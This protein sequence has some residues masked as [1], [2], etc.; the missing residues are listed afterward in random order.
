MPPFLQES[1]KQ[2]S[3]LS[4]HSFPVHPVTQTQ[5]KSFSSSCNDSY[6]NTLLVFLS[7]N[8]LYIDVTVKGTFSPQPHYPSYSLDMLHHWHMDGNRN[9]QCY[10]H[11]PF[12][13]I[14]EH[15]S[16]SMWPTRPSGGEEEQKI[17]VLYLYTLISA[18]VVTIQVA[19]FWQGPGSHSS[20]SV[21]QFFPIQPAI[22]EH[23]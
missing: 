13:C 7:K 6:N 1:G 10:P 12:P 23:V 4:L 16:K 5:L 20:I 22:Q 19:P 3:T 14:P 21:L 9:R 8:F 11:S 18:T 17:H 15:T 2:S